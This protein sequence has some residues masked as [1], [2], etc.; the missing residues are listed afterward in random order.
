[1]P[2]SK[3]AMESVMSCLPSNLQKDHSHQLTIP[4][5]LHQ[6]PCRPRSSLHWATMASRTHTC[7]VHYF[8]C[9]LSCIRTEWSAPNQ[10][11][12]YITSHQP[13]LSLATLV[14]SGVSLLNVLDFLMRFID[15][16]RSKDK[17]ECQSRL[18]FQHW[19]VE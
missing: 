12:T 18:L 19:E 5:D 17:V 1:M 6:G 10:E 9:L 7:Q 3:N 4:I 14:G 11:R 15:C 8:S 2:R 16:K 13:T